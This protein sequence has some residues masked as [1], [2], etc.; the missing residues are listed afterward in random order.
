MKEVTTVMMMRHQYRKN[1]AER[2]RTRTVVDMMSGV[3]AITIGPAEM[4]ARMIATKIDPAETVEMIAIT[5]GPVEMTVRMTAITTG[6]V[7]M[8]A[9]MIRIGPVGMIVAQLRFLSI[10]IKETASF[11]ATVKAND[12]KTD[13]GNLCRLC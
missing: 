5:T 10:F 6:H 12:H 9:E 3:I 7:E 1:L 2:K 13:T 8:T 11:A 4:A